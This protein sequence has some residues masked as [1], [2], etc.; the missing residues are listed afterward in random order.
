MT[1]ISPW[2]L[3]AE[4]ADPRLEPHPWDHL[5]RPDQQ[6]PAGDWLI[7]LLITGRRWGKT[8]SAAEWFRRRTLDQ[9]GSYAIC[10]PTYADVR[11]VCVE[12]GTPGTPSGLLS[13]CHPGEVANYNR[14]L[15]EIRMTNGSKIKML[16]ADEPDRAR[17]WGFHAAWC[18]EL[19]SWRYPATWYETLLPA[20]SMSD[21]HRFVVTTTPKPNLLTKALIAQA[22]ENPEEVRI[23]RGR[24]TDNAANLGAGVFEQLRRQMTERQARQE[25][26]GELLDDIEGALWTL[27]MIDEHRV[28][29]G[30]LDGY[31]G[32]IRRV[33]IGV[34]PAGS[35]NPESDHTGIVV[36]GVGADGRGYILADRSCQESPNGWGQAVVAAYREFSADRII[37]ERN[38]GG[39]MVE[40][41]IRTVAPNVPVT[42]VSA[43]KNKHLRAEPIA[44][45][46][47]Q[48]R[49][50]HA[51]V[52][53]ALEDELCTWVPGKSSG[54]PDRVDAMVYALTA[55]FPA[56][57]EVSVARTD[58]RRLTTGYR[59]R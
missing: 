46:Y 18:D 31:V 7:W 20:V 26:Y 37:A 8:R 48:G 58:D 32:G 43:Q 50:S 34:D 36:A 13:I 35:A 42:T 47:E 25:L 24:T 19:S 53:E 45:L 10:A 9:V 12:G 52:F 1:T 28:A 40:H 22:A 4:L 14:S 6:P 21:R 11:D 5:A 27:A 33:V 49:V 41:V 3:A 55:L 56:T 17:G 30:A 54:S 38:Y 57:R 2:L 51:G 59:A 15:G 29:P 44:A 16:S 23:V 39:D